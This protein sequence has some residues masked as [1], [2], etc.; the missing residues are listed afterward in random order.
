[1]PL[2]ELVS[3]LGEKLSVLPDYITI[4]GSGEPTLF[5]PL[6]DLIDRVKS[7]TDI[8]VAVL[9]NGS[10]LW[11]KEVRSE[12]MNADLVVPSLDAADEA[13]FR[14]VNRPHKDISFDKMLGGLIKMREEFQ[15]KYWLEIFLLGGYTGIEAEVTKLAKC[16][17]R[18]KPDRIQLNTVMRPPAEDFA[19]GISY[20]RMAKFAAMFNPP[21]E[22]IADFNDIHEKPEFF[23]G[24]AEILTMLQ[25]RPCSVDDIAGGLGMH[26]NEIVKYLEDLTVQNLVERSL[27]GGR[28][29][30]K[31]KH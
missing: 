17:D 4:S 26:R 9:T 15:G 18:I 16:V 23:S 27:V 7:M 20:D 6:G 8:P 13:M 29:F 22:V 11:K 30:Y 3:E 24:R 19:V 25:R 14:A 12:L 5:S 21:A 28:I 31:A 10:L 2:E 1:V